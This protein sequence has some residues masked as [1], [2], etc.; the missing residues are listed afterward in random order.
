MGTLY[1][2][3]FIEKLIRGEIYYKYFYKCVWFFTQRIHEV[4]VK[5]FKIE[6]DK[7]EM[8][9]HKEIEN[10]IWFFAK[11]EFSETS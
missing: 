2:C 9:Y 11:L 6:N 3:S 7:T 8:K 5:L 1:I 4:E 10:L